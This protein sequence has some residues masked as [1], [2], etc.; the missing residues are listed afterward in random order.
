MASRASPFD[1]AEPPVDDES[2]GVDDDDD[3]DG[4]AD[5]DD[6]GGDAVR[7]RSSLPAPFTACSMHRP[8]LQ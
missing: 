2:V 7:G 4:G 6:E 5:D 3:D 8:T 1:S